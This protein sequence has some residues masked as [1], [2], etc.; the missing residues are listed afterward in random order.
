MTRSALPAASTA[1]LFLLAGNAPE[2]ASLGSAHSLKIFNFDG[3]TL[4][5]DQMNL[6]GLRGRWPVCGPVFDHRLIVQPDAI[7]ILTGKS[8]KIVRS[9]VGNQYPCP[10]DGIIVRE[11]GRNPRESPREINFR[12]DA[13]ERR[14]SLQFCVRE[15]FGL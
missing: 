9:F 10:A 1:S 14:G 11:L 3:V 5:L 4:T 8:D 13:R 15:V 12:V 6:A 7:A 2:Q